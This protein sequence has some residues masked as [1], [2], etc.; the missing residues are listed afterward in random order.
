M[1]LARYICAR[2]PA[3]LYFAE[4]LVSM[5]TRLSCV[6]APPPARGTARIEL[7][8][9]ARC[10]SR[11]R[12]C[13]FRFLILCDRKRTIRTTS[14]PKPFMLT[15]RSF[16]SFIIHALVFET[17]RA[18][19]GGYKKGFVMECLCVSRSGIGDERQG[20]D[21]FLAAFITRLLD[22]SVHRLNNATQASCGRKYCP[23]ESFVRLLGMQLFSVRACPLE[24]SEKR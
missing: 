4:G 17:A 3:T 24:S 16:F 22:Q 1:R 10:S 15:V 19:G 5:W 13:V 20:A 7:S 23:G 12:P 14:T 9:P 11:G 2:P 6:R 21:T 8:F 18:D